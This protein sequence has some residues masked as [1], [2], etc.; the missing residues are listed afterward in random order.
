VQFCL[1]TSRRGRWGFPKGMI[2][3]GDTPLDTALS[4]AEEEAGL[5]G[6]LEAEP[7][8]TFKYRKWGRSLVVACYLM[9]V[10]EAD[11][12]WEEDDWRQRVWLT[13]EQ[14]RAAVHRPQVRSLIDR[15][16]ERLQAGANHPAPTAPM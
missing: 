11:D 9:R 12:E 10:D 6:E 8:G 2:D 7:L 5:T 13:A 4:E 1:I 3:R 14:A 16:I 15:A